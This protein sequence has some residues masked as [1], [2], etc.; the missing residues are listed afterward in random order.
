MK[1]QV[2]QPIRLAWA[3]SHQR[4]S[5]VLESV[6]TKPK[7]IRFRSISG[8]EIAKVIRRP[9]D[10]VDLGSFAQI[11]V[12]LVGALHEI[13]LGGQAILDKRRDD[14]ILKVATAEGTDQFSAEP[15]PF[16][17]KVIID[18]KHLKLGWFE[19]AHYSADDLI[20]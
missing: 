3:V 8:G 10:V 17:T 7:E 16:Q 9:A 6:A 15:Q 1:L 14:D 12:Q 19:C 13:G 2:P 5:L 18:A 4:A 20:N 11:V